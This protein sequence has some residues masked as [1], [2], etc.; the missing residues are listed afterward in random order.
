VG[1][2]LENYFIART[3]GRHLPQES[4][5]VT[6]ILVA[7]LGPK[8]E[9]VQLTGMGFFLYRETDGMASRTTRCAAAPGIGQPPE[10]ILAQRGLHRS[11]VM[12]VPATLATNSA[13][14]SA[15]GQGD[16]VRGTDKR[17]APMSGTHNLPPRDPGR[18]TAPRG[19][20]GAADLPRIPP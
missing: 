9:A 7:S 2:P 15:A 5:R 6:D 12:G 8:Q 14:Q 11:A 19:R 17:G 13:R 16:V 3:L 20:L 1:E 4:K 10:A 18:A